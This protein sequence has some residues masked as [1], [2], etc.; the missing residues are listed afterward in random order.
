MTIIFEYKKSII[1][2]LCETIIEQFEEESNKPL[3][4]IPKNNKYWE[5]IEHALY[6]ELLIRINDYKNQLLYNIDNNHELMISFNKSFYLQNFIIQKICANDII[7]NK[8]N[9]IP[10]RYNFLTFIFFLNTID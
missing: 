6:K 9:F 3:L 5:K 7:N 2:I 8:Y 4:N 1:P 10:N